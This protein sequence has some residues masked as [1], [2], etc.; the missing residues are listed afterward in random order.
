MKDHYKINWSARSHNYIPSELKIAQKIMKFADPLTKGKYLMKFE[1]DFKK[2]LNTKGAVF[3]VTSAASAIELT[4]ASLN[5]KPGDEI[6]VPAHTY[7]ASALPFT[8]YRVKIKWVDIDLN[9]MLL[10]VNHLKKLI[11]KKTK[12]VVAVHLYGQPANIID[13]KKIL[14][15]KRIVLVEDCAQALGAKIKNRK[16]GTF[17]DFSIFSLHAQKN[18]TTLGEGGILVVNNKKYQKFIP[19]LRHNGH[20]KFSKKKNYWKP[21]MVDVCQDI[22][23]ITPFNFPMTEV[24]A[25]LGSQLLKRVDKLNS[26]RILKAKKFI[27][28]MRNYP[29]L[30]FQGN[31]K[32]HKSVYHLLPAWFD[33][34]YTRINKDLFINEMSKKHKIKIIVQFYP[35]YKYD[36]FKKYSNQKTYL[37][38]T[39]KIFKNMVSFPFHEWMSDKDFNYM[40]S[41][42][43]KTINKLSKLK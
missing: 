35:L 2:Y 13:I 23:G 31:T 39:E 41:S 3:G 22:K 32:L 5:L 4:A 40:I 28:S 30:K 42:T 9:T 27:K 14:K 24:Q 7:C 8:R 26:R 10:S 16:V 34:N 33:K 37:K 15:K 20:R 17:G 29:F 38:N 25:A 19:G 11:G 1:K 36:F 12:A 21:A 43:K 18:I 6:I